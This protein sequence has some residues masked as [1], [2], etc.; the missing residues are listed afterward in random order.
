MRL[1]LRIR[2]LAIFMSVLIS[3]LCITDC[4]YIN[5]NADNSDD[6]ELSAEYSEKVNKIEYKVNYSLIGVSAEAHESAEYGVDYNVKF[7][8]MSGYTMPSNI[9]LI[10][11]G[12][13][14]DSS[15]YNYDSKNCTLLIPAELVTGEMSIAVTGLAETTGNSLINMIIFVGMGLCVITGL[16]S[17]FLLATDKRYKGKI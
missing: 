12:K 7:V 3:L 5:A 4:T 15:V 13:V 11:D 17:V 1:N 16:C 9:I 6:T 14:I 2:Y 10:A 8:P